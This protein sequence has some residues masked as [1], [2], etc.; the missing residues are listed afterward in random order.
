VIFVIGLVESNCRAEAMQDAWAVKGAE[1]AKKDMAGSHG[2]LL[3][4]EVA[5][6]ND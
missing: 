5:T 1:A 6:A 2:M 4:H 3:S